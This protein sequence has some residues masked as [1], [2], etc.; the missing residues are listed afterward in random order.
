MSE[1]DDYRYIQLEELKNGPI[2]GGGSGGGSAADR[3]LVVTAYRCKNAFSGASLGDTITCTQ[4]LDL[5]GTPSTVATIWRNQSTGVDLGSTPSASDLEFAGASGLTDTQLRA[6]AVAVSV[7]GAVALP[8]GAATETTV[9]A[10]NTKTPAL[11]SG[12][13]PVD[14][15]GVTQPVSAASLP[16]PTGASTS[17]LQTSGN[18]S[19]S[20]V[21]SKLTTSNG[22]LSSIDTKTPALGQAAM[23]A[24]TPVVIASNQSTLP[25]SA[26]SLPLP[27]GAATEVTS[28]SID[29]KL[30]ALV[31]GSI[32]VD[33]SAV[34]QPVSAAALPLP[35]GASTSALQTSA[36]GYLSSVDSKL[37]AIGQTDM[38]G[39]VP[40]TLAND[41]P[42]LSVVSPSGTLALNSTLL[43]GNAITKL[44]SSDKGARLAADL[45]SADI[46][47]DTQA[48]HV[49]VS[50]MVPISVSNFPATQPVSVSALPLPSGASTESTLATMSAKI[51]ALGVG[52]VATSLPVV[53]SSDNIITGTVSSAI[54]TDLLS[55]AVSGWFDAGAFQSASFQIIGSA[56]IS[57]GQIIFEQTNDTVNAPNGSALPTV[58]AAVLTADPIIATT[59]IAASTARVFE[60]PL[61]CRYVRIRISVAFV[62]GTVRAV[63][64]FS[65]RPYAS[66]RFTIR[67][68][69]AANLNATVAG[70]LTTVTTV[71][72]VTG[73]G[74]NQ[75]NV[76]DVASAALTTTTTTAALTQGNV[77]SSAVAIVVTVVSGTNPTLDVGVEESPDGGV[78][79]YRVFDFQRITAAGT[80]VSPVLQHTGN[81]IRYVQTVTG[82]TP[83]FTRSV[84]RNSFSV[85][86]VN[87]RSYKLLGLD[88]NTL[89]NATVAVYVD[90]RSTV[91]MVISSGAQ[92][93]APA[94]Q[95]EGS[96]DGLAWYALGSPVTTVASTQQAL[97]VSGNLARFARARVSTAGTGCT[98]NYVQIKAI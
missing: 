24:S 30:P 5:T 41:Q 95:L 49:A 83:S 62:G 60:A 48:L 44:R 88:P 6:S 65:Q 64:A 56:G 34:T 38:A 57:A 8:T 97:S 33:G 4:I 28:A 86:G 73:A 52:S 96:E 47:G 50:S 69:T 16:L 75:A 46:D 36:N 74:L 94:I 27:A 25:V 9:A 87:L 76:V 43:G 90:G 1:F 58:E 93:T 79:W 66:S 12:R 51:P 18:A 63:A 67:Q 59:A 32:P 26:A 15:S 98:N 84:S 21:D 7:S 85:P 53:L 39:S 78:N 68:A 54:N 17:A 10:I 37:P 55:G 89:N 35:A 29:S 23:A 11:V 70:A 77:Q 31:G 92:T 22:S 80:Y 71:T 14:A 20:S 82:T 91:N 72:N 2:T 81:R 61:T 3:E 13:V 19:L 42:A 40:V 45:T